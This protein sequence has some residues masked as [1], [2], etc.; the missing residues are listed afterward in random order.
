MEPARTEHSDSDISD[1]WNLIEANE[2][3]ASSLSETESIE[4]IGD[5]ELDSAVSAAED[6]SKN[7]EESNE[8]QESEA[9]DVAQRPLTPPVENSNA[10]VSDATSRKTRRPVITGLFS[11]RMFRVAHGYCCP[12]EK[13][14]TPICCPEKPPTPISKPPVLLM[15][16]TNFFFIMFLVTMAFSLSGNEGTLL[17]L[18][19]IKR[20]DSTKPGGRI[21]GTGDCPRILTLAEK[22][23]EYMRLGALAVEECRMPLPV[24]L[25]FVKV[26]GRPDYEYMP[27]NYKGR[28]LSTSQFEKKVINRL[29][30]GEYSNVRRECSQHICNRDS[31]NT[32]NGEMREA[33]RNSLNYGR[34]FGDSLKPSDNNLKETRDFEGKDGVEPSRMFD[35][36]PVE[37]VIIISDS[38]E[39]KDDSVENPPHLN[40]PNLEY[41][42][43]EDEIINEDRMSDRDNITKRKRSL[44]GRISLVFKSSLNLEDQKLGDALLNISTY[45]SGKSGNVAKISLEQDNERYLVAV[46]KKLSTI[47]NRIDQQVFEFFKKVVD[48]FAKNLKKIDERVEK[49]HCGKN[50]PIYG[51]GNRVKREENF[52][53]NGKSKLKNREEV[54]HDHENYVAKNAREISNSVERKDGDGESRIWKEKK[55]DKFDENKKRETGEDFHT[56]NVEDGE[57]RKRKEVGFDGR[58]KDKKHLKNI[59]GKRQDFDEGFKSVEVDRDQD[60]EKKVKNLNKRD[61]YVKNRGEKL[62]GSVNDQFRLKKNFVHMSFENI[63][64]KQDSNP[65]SDYANSD[66]HIEKNQKKLGKHRVE[67]EIDRETMKIEDKIQKGKMELNENIGSSSDMFLKRE[68]EANGKMDSDFI[69][70]VVESFER[71]NKEGEKEALSVEE[72]AQKPEQTAADRIITDDLFHAAFNED[73]FKTVLDN[74]TLKKNPNID[75][76]LLKRDSREEEIDANDDL[77]KNYEN[78]FNDDNYL[79]NVFNDNDFKRSNFGVQDL[80]NA[81]NSNW[82]RNCLRKKEETK[83]SRTES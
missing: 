46:L 3:L 82:K 13:R 52:Y 22:R 69:T 63:G 54:S 4:V 39:I 44:I 12:P 10:K 42:S 48:K 21:V 51:K 49:S 53:R 35:E 56:R 41:Q 32:G 77:R 20:C 78:G 50:C 83:R 25:A 68:I 64:E 9:E 73:T 58:K 26:I 55:N 79:K 5:S 6:G 60:E 7:E 16:F 75:D 29:E 38:Q 18:L 74:L 31:Q 19:N 43:V 66:V 70:N 62:K 24:F 72:E 33:D 2:T 15:F 45:L 59:D 61:I 65:K 36:N 17:K 1:G 28:Y 40:S 8:N 27:A 76:D 80:E 67:D 23:I 14:P 30:N 34:S 47:R 57:K 81:D 11:K 71:G 37:E